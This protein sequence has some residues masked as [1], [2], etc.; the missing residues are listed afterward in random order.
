MEKVCGYDPL[1][2]MIRFALTGSMYDSDL[3]PLINPD[4]DQYAANITFLVTPGVIGK[5]VG[6]EEVK[7]VPVL[8]TLC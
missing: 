4:F 7:K 2:M 3:A 6:A 5:I 8:L 1:D